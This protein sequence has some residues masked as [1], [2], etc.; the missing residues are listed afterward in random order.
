MAIIGKINDK[1]LIDDLVFRE[2]EHKRIMYVNEMEDYLYNHNYISKNK[3]K[4]PFRQQELSVERASCIVQKY[5]TLTE[6]K[7]KEIERLNNI[8]DEIKEKIDD[9]F[10]YDYENES[11]ARLDVINE[12]N[13]IIV[14]VKEGK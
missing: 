12:I 10:A 8:I 11:M 9:Y 14:E 13:R 6:E 3:D 1:V 5:R 7:D 2:E 4:D